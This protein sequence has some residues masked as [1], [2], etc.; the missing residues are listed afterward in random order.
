MGKTALALAM[1][2]NA[3]L[4][5]EHPTG[6]AIFSLEM[7]AHQLAQRLLT[8]E[9]RVDAQAART[10]RLRDDDWPHLA[11][12]AGRLSE[13]SIFIDDTP[14]LTIL[15]LRAK[16]RRLKAEHGI[17]LV[18]VDYLQLMHGTL[19]SKNSNREQEIAHISRSLK[20]LAKELSVPVIAL[21]QL[22]R[23]V[24]TRGGDKRPMLSDLRESGSIEQDADVVCF[25]YRAERY[26]IT[27]DE[28]GNST[29]GLAEVLV[30]KQRNGPTGDVTLAFVN[31]Y[32]RFENL[33]TY[34]GPGDFKPEDGDGAE[35]ASSD[36][37]PF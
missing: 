28:N 37:A 35:S 25:I 7:S 10:G 34:Y 16:C 4:H 8:A 36:Q 30:S 11:R 24:E 3:A 20:S 31:Q 18:M 22:S 5:P 13:A 26:G 21:S 23:A 1:A 15:E 14:G 2:R 32:A 6:V 27:V 33:T 19:S 9:A 17:G 29:E 12:A